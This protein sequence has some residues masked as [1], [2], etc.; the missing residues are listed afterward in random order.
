MSISYDF[1]LVDSFIKNNQDKYNGK[2]CSWNLIS[3]MYPLFDNT[4]RDRKKFKIHKK[5]LDLINF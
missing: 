3:S 4:L 2:L 5:C 1:K